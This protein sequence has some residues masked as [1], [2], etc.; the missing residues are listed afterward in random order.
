M[1]FVVALILSAVLGSAIAYGVVRREY[2]GRDGIFDAMELDG[3]IT[4]ANALSHHESGVS[5]TK[6]VAATPDGTSFDFGV[7]KM[8][9]KGEHTFTIRNDGDEDLGLTVGAST[10]KCTL[11][12]LESNRLAPGE[13]TKVKLEWTVSTTKSRFRQTAEIRTTD[14]RNLAVQLR[15]SGDVVRE[16]KMVPDVMNFGDVAAGEE[17]K[18]ESVVYSFMPERIRVDSVTFSGEELNELADIQVEEIEPDSDSSFAKATQAFRVIVNVKPGLRQGPIFQNLL[19]NFETVDEN[20]NRMDVPDGEEGQMAMMD[21]RVL[22]R[23]V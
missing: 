16:L 14:P 17:I 21:Y 7:M 8:G 20:G 4:A 11:G 1:K 23:V 19:F 12:S 18:A 9:E 2:A 10:C 3:E 13:S 15:I 22:G 6:P 5:K